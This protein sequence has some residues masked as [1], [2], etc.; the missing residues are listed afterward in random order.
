[1]RQINTTFTS[2]NW[3]VNG[4]GWSE[5]SSGLGSWW[6]GSLIDHRH[7][8]DFDDILMLGSFRGQFFIK[9]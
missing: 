2:L 8:S 4:A 3:T 6:G 1:M 9:F 5:R 7:A